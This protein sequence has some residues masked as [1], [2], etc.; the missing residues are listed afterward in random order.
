MSNEAST[1]EEIADGISSYAGESGGDVQRYI[2]APA[3][4]ELMGPANGKEI[5]DLYCGAG[6]FARRLAS[7][8]AN[9]TAVDNSD[10][11]VGIAREINERE[12][13]NIQYAVAEPNDLSVIE[14]SMFDDIVCNMGLMSTRDLAG[15][16]AALARLVKLGGRFIFSIAHPCFSMPDACWIRDADG[17]LLYEAVDN[18]YAERWWPSNL[19]GPT[20]ERSKIKHRTLATYVNALSVRGFNVRRISEPRPT[21]EV[22]TLKPHLAIFERVPAAMVIEAIFPYL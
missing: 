5:L 22:L 6:Y 17:K 4:L 12:R 1:Y 13:F 16:V 20:K 2:V 14:D 3:I 19:A 8:G 18:Y 7:L 15:T 11:L 9:V 10:R 21:Q